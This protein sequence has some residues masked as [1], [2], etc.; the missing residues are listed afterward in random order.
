MFSNVHERGNDGATEGCDAVTEGLRYDIP[1]VLRQCGDESKYFHNADNGVCCCTSCD[2]LQ[3]EDDQ[4][5]M[6]RTMDG[7]ICLLEGECK[8]ERD[9]IEFPPQPAMMWWLAHR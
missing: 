6:L 5:K 3:C 7:T 2:G 8:G 1:T 9:F 4:V